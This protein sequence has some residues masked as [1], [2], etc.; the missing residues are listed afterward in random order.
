MRS[1]TDDFL[2]LLISYIVLWS[3]N[4]CAL[5]SV[6]CS[7]TGEFNSSCHL[8]GSCYK[9]HPTQDQVKK[10]KN[11][12]VA[13]PIDSFLGY[14]ITECDAIHTGFDRCPARKAGAI[15]SLVQSNISYTVIPLDV[16]HFSMDIRW[17]W[18]DSDIKSAQEQLVGYELR[19]QRPPETVKCLCIWEP[20]LRNVSLGFDHRLQ[21]SSSSP[22]MK[23]KIFNLPF[24]EEWS[25]DFASTSTEGIL[26]P[27][28]CSDYKVA[29]KT[30]FCPVHLPVP[31]TLI[32]AQ[33]LPSANNTKELNV[34]W[35]SESPTPETYYIRVFND[36]DNAIFD[37]N[38]K[39]SQSIKIT[40]LH[41]STNYSV[42][43]QG[44]S[45]CSGLSSFY[46][47]FMSEVG[48]GTFS[49]L[50]NE[51]LQEFRIPDYSTGI[52]RGI[53]HNNMYIIIITSVISSLILAILIV[54]LLSVSIIYYCIRPRKQSDGCPDQLASYVIK[55]EKLDALVLYAQDTPIKQQ[56]EIE[57]NVVGLLKQ[58]GLN[59]LSCNDHTEKTVMQWVEENTR[60]A[61][62]VLIVCSKQFY[63]EWGD[64]QHRTAFI[65]SLEM[66]VA[67]AV[68]VN[69]IKKYATVLLMASDRQYIPN[70]QYL[71]GMKSFVVGPKATRNRAEFISFV[72][73]NG[74]SKSSF[75]PSFLQSTLKMEDKDKDER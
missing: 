14:N 65:N 58:N 17:S 51:S 42:Q 52:P 1:T 45:Q 23:I 7:T 8:S 3:K 18:F 47:N 66:I 74:L 44:Y 11:K 68:G 6:T 46:S 12:E 49:E 25:E 39:G 13:N 34:S 63:K 43:V 32:N 73:R 37:F 64:M 50:L 24:R 75:I 57:S 30:T 59:V 60:L 53:S 67:S 15:R 48:C 28:T 71:K 4:G 55:P 35:V 70:H 41:I 19:I 40:G 33:S 54:I 62:T 29:D 26:W 10:C 2:A 36:L 16:R 31:P 69:C 27:T 20:D 21:Y 56:I 22:D 61:G 5:A 9:E 38:V 72:Q